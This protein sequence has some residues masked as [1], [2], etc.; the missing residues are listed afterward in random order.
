MTY[1]ICWKISNFYVGKSKFRL[2]FSKKSFT[3]LIYFIRYSWRILMRCWKVSTFPVGK[4]IWPWIFFQNSDEI[5]RFTL[6]SRIN[7]VLRLLISWLFSRGY[8]L[9]LVSI[10]PILVVHISIRYKWGYAYSFCQIFQGLRLFK[11]LRL[12]QTLEYI[13][14]F[15]FYKYGNK[16]IV[17]GLLLHILLLNQIETGMEP[18]IL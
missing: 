7:I 1:V 17:I 18:K 2:V 9:I 16:E 13:R 10:E 12:F 3:M 6:E 14:F 5:S 8:G 15:K 4:G 11:G